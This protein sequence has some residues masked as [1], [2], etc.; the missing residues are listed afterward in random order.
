[1]F[2]SMAE[3]GIDSRVYYFAPQHN[4][5]E[6][7]FENNV[8]YVECYKNIDR[9]L[10]KH[11][12][13]KVWAVFKQLYSNNLPEIIHAHSLFS[14][15]YIA[16]LANREFGIPYIVAVRNTDIN[17]FFRKRPYLRSLGLKIL[18]SAAK[19]VFISPSYEKILINHYLDSNC[20]AAVKAKSV[21]IPNGI[22][23]IFLKNQP[24]D[25]D[26]RGM[27]NDLKVLQ[28]G[29]INENKNQIAVAIALDNL[30]K[31]GKKV[32]FKVV[33]KIKN[34]RIESQLRKYDFVTLSN[35]VSHDKL[36][37]Y[38]RAADVFA[39]PSKY[40]TFGLVYAEAMSQGLPVVYTKGQ[41]FDGWAANG[42]VGMVVEY[43]NIDDLSYALEYCADNKGMMSE[44]ILELS[45]TF[46]WSRIS[47]K[48]FELYNDILS[49]DWQK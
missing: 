22:A 32:S 9:L 10:F 20:R 41:G 35:P 17:V 37:E 15:G 19:I 44:S 45:K 33:G 42:T 8:D 31:K 48:Y 39:M 23:D 6:R 49:E 40:E 29:D 13:K 43:G 38:Y 5:I 7:K 26:N 12:E 21:V 4:S 24:V 25:F 14:N 34:S 36:I 11:K 16:Y 1:M 2:A 46:S 28:V 30:R 47:D 18:N 3:S 27:S